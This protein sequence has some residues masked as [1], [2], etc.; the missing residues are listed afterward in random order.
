MS[1]SLITTGFGLVLFGWFLHDMFIAGFQ[2]PMTLLVLLFPV[3]LVAAGVA[4][5]IRAIRGDEA[6]R[7][8]RTGIGALLVLAPLLVLAAMPLF[9]ILL[10]SLGMEI[11][12][13]ASRALGYT[14][15]LCATVTLCLCFIIGIR[16]LRN[17]NT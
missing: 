10:G 7:T 5:A 8:W 2:S 12:W 13:N 6:L 16:L 9:G 1:G 11:H 14:A 3:L 4:I 15:V 17:A